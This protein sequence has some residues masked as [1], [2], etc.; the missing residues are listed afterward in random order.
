MQTPS[1]H[2]PA[3]APDTTRKRIPSRRPPTSSSARLALL[4]IVGAALVAGGL[5]W[6]DTRW[7]VGRRVDPF[8]YISGARNLAA[9]LGLVLLAGFAT[10]GWKLFDQG[11]LRGWGFSH[12]AW[13]ASPVQHAIRTLPPVTIYTNEPDPVYFLTGRPSYI[14]FG[15]TDPVTGLPRQGYDEW[16]GPA[17]DTLAQGSAALVLGNVERPMTDAEVSHHGRGVERRPAERKQGCGR[18]IPDRWWAAVSR[19]A[20]RLETERHSQRWRGGELG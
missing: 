15:A 5:V 16:L 3:T 17:K 7:G 10:D 2:S 11:W 6:A 20:A 18:S 12:R 13:Q 4:M 8:A 1:I 14:V 19:D 9:G